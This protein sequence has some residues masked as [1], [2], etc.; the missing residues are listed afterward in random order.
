MDLLNSQNS[1]SF[2]SLESTK[3]KIDALV[4]IA[5]TFKRSEFKILNESGLSEYQIQYFDEL[6]S[7]LR[8]IQDFLIHSQKEELP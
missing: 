4:E 6:Y 2:G 7:Q 3:L 1:G 8:S 5:G